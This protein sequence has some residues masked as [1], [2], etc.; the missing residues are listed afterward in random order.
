MIT[1]HFL[2][3]DSDADLFSRVGRPFPGGA[4][5]NQVDDGQ[6]F[7]WLGN[8]PAAQH[9][10]DAIDDTATMEFSFSFEFV[11]DLSFSYGFDF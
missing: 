2:P 3:I 10:L 5:D 6:G 9:G 1:F 4:N 7:L 11:E 8:F